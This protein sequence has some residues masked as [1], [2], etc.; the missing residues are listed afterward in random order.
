MTRLPDFNRI[1][2]A[3]GSCST[4]ISDRLGIWWL[5]KLSRKIEK[6]HAP[7]DFSMN[8]INSDLTQLCQKDGKNCNMIDVSASKPVDKQVV[9]ITHEGVLPLPTAVVHQW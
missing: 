3:I 7:K 6:L 8:T 1:R 9:P 4:Q 5:N 2:L